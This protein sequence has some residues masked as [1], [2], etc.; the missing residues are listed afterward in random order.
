MASRNV[1]GTSAGDSDSDTEVT[2]LSGASTK[3]YVNYGDRMPYRP[4]RFNMDRDTFII[5]L[6]KRIDRFRNYAQ[7]C[8]SRTSEAPQRS[9]C[10]CT[11]YIFWMGLKMPS[12]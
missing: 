6:N 12:T 1:S 9:V 5:Y 2:N 3:P 8:N 4:G 10:D 7:Y 11:F